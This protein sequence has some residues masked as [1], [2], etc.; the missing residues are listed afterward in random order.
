M[1]KRYAED[2]LSRREAT[3][4]RRIVRQMVPSPE[5]KVVQEAFGSPSAI[6]YNWAVINPTAAILPGTGPAQRLGSKIRV[7]RLDVIFEFRAAVNPVYLSN[8]I[9]YGLIRAED[10]SLSHPTNAVADGTP[11]SFAELFDPAWQSYTAETQRFINPRW[12]IWFRNMNIVQVEGWHVLKMRHVMLKGAS[13]TGTAT[14]RE[15][16]QAEGGGV[17][18]DPDHTIT[19][20]DYQNVVGSVTNQNAGAVGVIS[21]VA[22]YFPKDVEQAPWRRRV[23]FTQSWPKG[24][25][26]EYDVASDTTNAYQTARN[27]LY[28]FITSSDGYQ[29]ANPRFF[30]HYVASLRIWFTD[31]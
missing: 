16:D 7:R 28:I 15:S 22:Q 30:P 26:V 11:G 18:V 10:P 13:F 2:S 8:R 6:P 4:V 21:T 12:G 25:P 5:W 3:S 27:H 17:T 19:A 31:E 24:L 23:R 20:V 1:P 29:G 9:T 14:R